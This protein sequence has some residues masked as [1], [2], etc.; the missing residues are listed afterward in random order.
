MSEPIDQESINQFF[1]EHEADLMRHFTRKK[2]LQT[3]QQRIKNQNNYYRRLLSEDDPELTDEQLKELEEFWAPYNF[4]CELDPTWCRLYTNKTGRFDPRYIPNPI[5]YYFT[6][7]QKINFEYLRAFTDKNYLALIFPFIK[8]PVT[9][10][11]RVRGLYYNGDFEPISKEQAV[12]ICMEAKGEGLIIKPSVSSW[13]GRN[14]SFFSKDTTVGELT[15]TLSDYGENYIIEKLL[16]QSSAL[17]AIHAESVNTL[18][19]ISIIHNGKPMIMSRCIRMGVGESR[20]DNFSQGGIGCGINENG[21]LNST[22]YD[23]NGKSVDRHPS[24]FN[25]EDCIIPNFEKVNE[26]ILRLH[27]RVPMFGVTSWDIALDETNEPVL[28]EY[29]VG[30]GGI[31]IHQYNNGPL[32]GENTKEILDSVFKDYSIA[33]STIF[34]NFRRF[35]DHVKVTEGAK[36]FKDIVICEEHDG[37]PVKEIDRKAFMNNKTLQSV[38]I[39]GSVTHIRY[40]AFYGCSNLTR[41][42]LKK[43]LREIGRSA[44]NNCANLEEVRLPI[45]VRRIR[46]RAFKDCP[47]LKRIRIP[48]SVKSISSEAFEGSNNVTIVCKKDSIAHAYAIEHGIQF[49]LKS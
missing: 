5:H 7:Y 15:E 21:Q 23:L 27:S 37:A 33:D 47:N 8:H 9:V 42:V 46:M 32:Y 14:I 24:G 26:M 22:G 35:Q 38:E 40:C 6:E 10:A 49:E 45:G 18:R 11:R 16:K 29:N 39:P 25:F 36:T 48:S 34:Y 1:E 44:F 43:G 20:V 13:G 3:K 19:I 41:V 28:I 17:A 4:A 30:Q 2:A 31:D 12:E